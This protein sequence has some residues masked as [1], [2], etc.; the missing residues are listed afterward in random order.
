MPIT[1]SAK[2]RVRTAQRAALRNNRSKRSLSRALKTFQR[3]IKS[4][5]VGAETAQRKAQ[6]ELDKAYKKKI[7]SKHKVARKQRKLAQAAKASAV[8]SKAGPAK[9]RVAAKPKAKKTTAKKSTAK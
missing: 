7:M 9:R 4:G 3:T 5:K 2:K 8:K 6:S 1:K